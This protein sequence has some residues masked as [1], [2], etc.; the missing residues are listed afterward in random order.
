MMETDAAAQWRFPNGATPLGSSAYYSVRFS[1]RELRDDLAAL[2]AWRQEVRSILDEV[3]DPGVARLKLQ[4]WREELQRTYEGNPRH[5]LSTALQSTV[6]NHALPSGP[7]LE[8]AGQ[9]EDEILRRQPAD[10]GAFTIS[11]ERDL[12]ALFDLAA[13]C[14]GIDDQAMLATARTLGAFCTLVYIIRDSGALARMGRAVMPAEELAEQGLSASALTERAHRERL[15]ELL[16][17]SGLR[18]RNL[19]GQA[20]GFGNLPLITRVRTALL[21]AL[22][23]ELE[24]MNFDVANQRVSLTALRKLWLAWRESR[25]NAAAS[26]PIK[27]V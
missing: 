3:S 21:E 5:P 20:S 18:A 17:G 6:V 26:L 12:G 15:P 11:C 19:L 27:S 22:L 16:S 4:W 24:E 25:M 8:M 23:R 14:H 1:P 7:F 10:T 13:R 9:V 2:L